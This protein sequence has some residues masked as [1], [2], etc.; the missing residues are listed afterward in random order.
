MQL[1]LGEIGVVQIEH[2]SDAVAGKVDF[3]FR[4]DVPVD[5]DYDAAADD[6]RGAVDDGGWGEAADGHG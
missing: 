2:P 5:V 4:Q 6:A 3:H 1:V